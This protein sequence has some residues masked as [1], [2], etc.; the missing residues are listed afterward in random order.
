MCA[1]TTRDALTE[2]FATGNQEE[3]TVV[4]RGGV[5]LLTTLGAPLELELPV[6][7]RLCQF[8][9]VRSVAFK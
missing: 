8:V 7:I 2:I 1:I 5:A 6:S 3:H 4:Q 9:K